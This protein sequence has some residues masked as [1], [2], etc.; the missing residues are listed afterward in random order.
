MLAD[1]AKEKYLIC[2]ETFDFFVTLVADII[3]LVQYGD[4]LGWTKHAFTGI[5]RFLCAP[6]V[7]I[8]AT[9]T[10]AEKLAMPKLD[11]KAANDLHRRAARRATT[12]PDDS[13]TSQDGLL[14]AC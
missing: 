7:Y 14:G 6:L 3:I 11:A 2:L 10:H 8:F 5:M 4:K 12:K 1:P 9:H 13:Y